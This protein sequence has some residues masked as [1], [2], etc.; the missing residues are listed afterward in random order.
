LFQKTKINTITFDNTGSNIGENELLGLLEMKE[1]NQLN[2][3][4]KPRVKTTSQI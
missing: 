2:E 1:G 4:D 3:L